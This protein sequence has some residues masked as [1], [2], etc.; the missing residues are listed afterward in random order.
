MFDILIKGGRVINGTGNPWFR[1]DVG[2]KG[3]RIEAVE[4][5]LEAEAR[6]TI[7]AEGLVVCPGFIDM[8]SHSDIDLLVNPLAEPKISQGVTTEVI[9]QDGIG[10]APVNAR[11]RR[12]WQRTISGV[13]GH[14]DYPWTWESLGSYLE[15]LVGQS[16]A[17]NVATLLPHGNLR[18]MISGLKDRQLDSSERARLGEAAAAS[19]DEGAFGLS[20]GLIYMPC[21][22]ADADELTAMSEA[23]SGSGLPLVVHI[24]NEG[25]LLLESIEEML[26]VG[27]RA[28]VPIHI[29]H[30]KAAG[31]E[32]WNLLD[33]A[34]ELVEK[35]RDGGVDVSFDQYPYSAAST[36]LLAILPP[37]MLEGGSE[38]IV[39]R[40]GDPGLRLKV[41]RQIAGL[42]PGPETWA[43]TARGA[44]WDNILVTAV[45]SEENKE[46]EGR[47][48]QDIA[49]ARGVDPAETAL[50]LLKEENCSVSMAVFSMEEEGVRKVMQHR[51]QMVGTDG[52]MGGKPHPRMGGTYPRILGRYCRQEGVLSLEEAVRK[53]SSYPAQ[54]LGIR[55]RGILKEGLK[56]DVTVFDPER[57]IDLNSFQDP[58]K[59]SPGV[60]HVL[61][62]GRPVIAEGKVTGAR[63]GRVLSP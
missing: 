48:L 6:Q 20:T 13:T 14:G 43:N 28:S 31:K 61:V 4:P 18:L 60:R 33:D 7:E 63:P 42:E 44:G 58:L 2:I 22:Y 25:H 26:A 3:E 37:W 36:T 12:T 17:T 39:Q 62:N 35:A 40:L 15:E 52:L 50:D 16:T 23:L 53:C 51:Y 54:R 46:L 38:D 47:S 8:H 9:G 11:L 45:E 21:V 57:I 56:A 29:S 32:N 1:A 41:A 34:L 5:V 10:P 30:F 24:R 59:K 19:L 55:D 49:N 27:R